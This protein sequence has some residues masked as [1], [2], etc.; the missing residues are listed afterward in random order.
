MSLTKYVLLGRLDMQDG[1][2]C[3]TSSTWNHIMRKYFEIILLRNYLN[4]W[5]QLVWISFKNVCY[6]GCAWL[7]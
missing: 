4:V 5:K 3:S 2:H 1:N 6:S 7:T